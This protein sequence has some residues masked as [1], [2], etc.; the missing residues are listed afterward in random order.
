MYKIYIIYT[1]NHICYVKIPLQI[2][3]FKMKLKKYIY[4]YL[5]NIK[6][7]EFLLK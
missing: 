5:Y 6:I 7:L 1:L 2:V 4:I 3:Y